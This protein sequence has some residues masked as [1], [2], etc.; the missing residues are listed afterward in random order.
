MPEYRIDGVTLS[1]KLV[2]GS[3]TAEN[4]MEA[5]RKAEQLAHER[6][7]KITGVH[8]RVTYIYRVKKGDD[9]PI[10]GEQKAYTADEVRAALEKMG[11][12]VIYVRKKLFGTRPRPAPMTD[13]VTF[14]RVSADLM[15]QKLPFNEILQLLINDITHP[16]LREAIREI[17]TELK[18]G[19]DSEKAFQ[20]QSVV[21][22]K[23][24][25]NML[26]LASK[27]GNMAEI[28]DSTAKFLERTAEFKR[29]LRSA[30]VT[31]M[32]TLFVLFV[33]CLYYVAYIF[34]E[35]AKMFAKFNIKLPPMTAATLK[36]SDWLISNIWLVAF[37]TI[38]PIVAFGL[39]LRTEKGQFYKDKFIIKI[40]VLG[41]LFHR[42]AIEIFC[43]V[44][45][46]LYSGS[47][48]NIEIIR[49]AAEA[50]GNKYME[51]QIKTIA[52]PMMLERG[53]GLTE[54]FE[55]TGVFTK[56][57]LSR[58]SSGAETGTVKN[59]ALQL[60][61]YYEKETTYRLKNAIEAISLSVN[62]IIMI[63]LT[64][65]TI[66][67]SETALIKPDTTMRRMILPLLGLW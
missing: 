28:Y 38:A 40:P 61:E 11:F 34:P 25:A 14:V 24:A 23:F 45:Y 39:F 19:K 46:A 64:A 55:A 21:L 8:E 15:R 31:P 26:G 56:T 32:I 16:G 43:R 48:E 60:A 30:L 1:G 27:S 17:N 20:K 12:K 54:A 59:T 58:F 36:L 66:V 33:A 22:G 10:D 35:T 7:F 49:M 53:K 29:N 42:T 57:A 5:K 47:G 63:V 18:Q 2:S 67:S 4:R 37:F 50:C 44:F 41:S 3:I 13:V 51:H 62:M 9:K 65:L 6:K 52:I